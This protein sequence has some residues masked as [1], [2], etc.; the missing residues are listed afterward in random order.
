MLAAYAV[1]IGYTICNPQ[2][3]PIEPTRFDEDSGIPKW[4]LQF[5]IGDVSVWLTARGWRVGRLVNGVFETATD[6]DFY[7]KLK[8]ALDEGARNWRDR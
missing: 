2:N 1:S 5:T 7:S 6:S 8:P 4:E 3:K